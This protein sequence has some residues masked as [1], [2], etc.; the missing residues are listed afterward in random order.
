MRTARGAYARSIR[1][2]LHA[3]GIDDLPRNGAFV[4]TN[5]DP[6]SG[7]RGDL[8]SGLGVTKQAVSQVIDVLVN[9]G[10]LQ[11]RPDPDD[12]RR[13]TLSLTGRGRQA[14]EAVVRGVEA[15][16]RQLLEQVSPEQIDAMRSVLIRLTE[17]K[18]ADLANGSGRERPA[19]QLRHFS[20]IFRCA[21]FRLPS[22]TTRRSASRRSLTPRVTST[23][24]PT[25]KASGCTSPPTLTT[26]PPT[27]FRHTSTSA[28]P[29]P[30]TR[31][32]TR[33]ELGGARYPSDLRLTVYARVRMSTRTAT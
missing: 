32:G 23:D 1:A 18:R 21:I 24:S 7:L 33:Q 30:F 26:I 31:N 25:E 11:R 4:L 5:V 28:T 22:R 29:M 3:I 8:S 16:D 19:R 10:Y 27:A 9:R 12:R 17:I 2:Q 20:P 14:M 13:V 6:S 15:V